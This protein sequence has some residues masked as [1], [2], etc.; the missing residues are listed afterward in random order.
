MT[1]V[2]D[3]D[4]SK[5]REA[6]G[7]LSEGPPLEVEWKSNSLTRDKQR[8]MTSQRRCRSGPTPAESDNWKPENDESCRLGDNES[9]N[10]TRVVHLETE[11][12][13]K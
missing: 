9:L 11:E 1:R 12:P 4:T 7:G 5:A 13:C 10:M 3:Y 8:S 6:D 2:L